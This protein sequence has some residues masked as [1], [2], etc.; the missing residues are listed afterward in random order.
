MMHY[1][2]T[3]RD[4]EYKI[5]IEDEDPNFQPKA[6]LA[7]LNLME[8]GKQFTIKEIHSLFVAEVSERQVRR[9]VK[10]LEDCG[11]V[12]NIPNRFESKNRVYCASTFGSSSSRT[13]TTDQLLSLYVLKQ[14]IL[15]FKNSFLSKEIETIILKIQQ[16]FG[17]D[18]SY[19]LD[20]QDDD[21]DE[22]TENEQ[23]IYW[24]QLPGV[25]TFDRSLPDH[26]LHKLLDAT[27]QRN[28]IDVTFFSTKDN[29]EK[30]RRVFPFIVYSYEGLLY[31]YMYHPGHKKPFTLST[32]HIK[33]IEKVDEEL[34]IIP[35][36]QKEFL[37][38]RFAV[39][40]GKLE[41]VSFTI[42]DEFKHLFENRSWHISQTTTTRNG[43]LI[44]KMVVP[45]K[46]DFISWVIRWS[47][48]FS[49]I[50]PVSL[51]DKVI[52]E[53]QNVINNFTESN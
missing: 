14:L 30:R 36:N 40:E 23:K 46:P 22:S 21:D 25:A 3:N 20:P 35:F 9:Y 28:W 38:S 18:F 33:K 5:V 43:K 44:V 37:L 11:L 53:L 8:L 12:T 41:N 49:E 16:S 45:L 34:N 17:K 13:F 4:N 2:E 52:S 32:H 42:K 19:F 26:I 47:S 51:K 24:N 29:I 15:S 10:I 39:F 7:I 48:A 27:L 50:K 1:I 6:V 31:A